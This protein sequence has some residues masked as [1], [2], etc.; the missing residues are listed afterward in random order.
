[1]CACRQKKT[2]F[3]IKD[4]LR[5][6]KNVKEIENRNVSG[7]ETKNVMSHVQEL[8]ARID[9][10]RRNTYPVCPTPIKPSGGWSYK[11]NNFERPLYS[12]PMLSS[13]LLRNQLTLNRF[14]T[15]APFNLRPPYNFD[16]GTILIITNNNSYLFKFDN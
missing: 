9:A 14:A 4:I 13:E 5:T 7:S 8:D 10:E 1:M 16:R 2:S 6:D 12:D 15:P 11:L 3:F